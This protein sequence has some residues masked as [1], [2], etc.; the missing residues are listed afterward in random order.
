MNEFDVIFSSAP[1]TSIFFLI[2][3]IGLFAMAAI[4][5]GTWLRGVRQRR[6]RQA[7]QPAT[8]WRIV[9]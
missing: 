4:A 1:A 5:F 8:A 7:H 3:T 2:S 9:H 6:A